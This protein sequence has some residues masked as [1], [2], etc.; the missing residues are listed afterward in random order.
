MN[1]DRGVVP[2]PKGC[3]I[4]AFRVRE[5]LI[6]HGVVREWK[7]SPDIPDNGRCRRVNAATSEGLKRK[8]RKGTDILIAIPKR[9]T[10]SP[11]TRVMGCGLSHERGSWEQGVRGE[12]FSVWGNVDFEGENLRRETIIVIYLFYI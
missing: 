12:L 4:T 9:Q 5:I 1:G 11:T 7:I 8:K 10:N 3:P 6:Q 2:H